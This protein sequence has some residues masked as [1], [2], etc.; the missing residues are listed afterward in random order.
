MLAIHACTS[1]SVLRGGWFSSLSIGH[2]HGLSATLTDR[3]ADEVPSPKKEQG[4]R[5]GGNTNAKL[6]V[7]G[8]SCHEVD[9]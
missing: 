7:A 2:K 5:E 6:C 3:L 1:A 8:T 9:V 4:H